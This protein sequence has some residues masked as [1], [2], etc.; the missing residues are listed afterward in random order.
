[1]NYAALALASFFTCACVNEE[2][3]DSQAG[4]SRP[5]SIQT[6]TPVGDPVAARV[7][8]EV[9]VE[10]DDQTADLF[11]E[12][13]EGASLPGIKGVKYERLFPDA[14]EWE[15]RHR[16][17]G[18]HKWFKVIYEES[19]NANTAVAVL[20]EVRGVVT[21]EAPMEKKLLGIPFNDPYAKTYQW[22]YFNDGTMYNGFVKGCDINV[23]PVWENYTAGDSHVIVSIV[24]QGIQINHPDLNGVVLAGGANGS[25]NFTTG[26]Y[27]ITAGEH[28]CHVA[29]IVGGINNNGKGICGVAGGSDGKGGVTM[30]SCQ[31]FGTRSGDS[32]A[33]IVWG[34]DHGAVISQNSWGYNYDYNNDG[35]L[36]GSEYTAAMNATISS[37]DKAA[38]DYFVK[39]A[40]CDSDGNQLPD[41]PMKG[42]IVIFAAG[43]DNVGNGA[44]AN[45]SKVMA[46]GA[47]GPDGKRASYSN[48]GDW[49]DICAPGGE[50]D[51][52]SSSNG[53]S[54]IL[55][56]VDGSDYG[57]MCGTSMACPMVSGVAALVVSYFGGQGFTNTELW[58]ML[59]DNENRT[60]IPSSDKIAGMVDAYAI[61]EAN[62]NRND[63]PVISTDYKGDFRV[64]V[65]ESLSVDY[66]LTDPEGE[67]CT[68]SISGDGSATLSKVSNGKYRLT[69][70]GIAKNIGT[71]KATLTAKD[72]RD[73]ETS[74]EVSYTI[75]QNYPP[76]IST[77]YTGNYK[78][79]VGEILSINY[80]ATDQDGDVCTFTFSGD[81]SATMTKTGNNSCRV[82][83]KTTAANV[84][85]H[86]ATLKAADGKG[87]EDSVEIEYVILA[88]NAPIIE[89]LS[90]FE[91]D[92]PVGSDVTL[93]YKVTDPDGDA[94]TVS[95]ES[96]GS[97]LLFNGS[98]NNFSV[99]IQTSQR[100]IGEHTSVI[101]ATDATGQKT[102]ETI[103][104]KIYQNY[105]PVISTT[106]TGDYTVL[107]GNSLSIDFS[108]TDAN[109]DEL[110]VT[111]E[112]D[113]SSN[114]VKTAPGAY[115]VVLDV[116]AA[117]AGVHNA[118]IKADDSKGG[119]TTY[120]ITYTIINNHTPKV[121]LVGTYENEVAVGQS[122]QA[123]VKV[124]DQD[125][126]QLNVTLEGDGSSTLEAL[127]GGQY[128]VKFKAE[129][130]YVG[131]HTVSVKA[132]DPYGASASQ[133]ITY[134]I[135]V[136]QAPVIKTSYTGPTVLKWYEKF[137]ASFSATDPEGK[138][139]LKFS[140]VSSNPISE[141]KINGTS[142]TVNIGDGSGKFHGECTITAT[143]EDVLGL[144]ASSTLTYTVLENR[145][146][147]L[148]RNLSDMVL[149]SSGER[150][151]LDLS[152]YWSEPDGE[153]MTI[154][155]VSDNQDV[156]SVSGSGTTYF[157]KA[158]KNGV[159]TITMTAKDGFGAVTTKE[160]KIGVYDD[161]VGPTLYPN[162]VKTNLYVRV[163]YEREVK[164]Q[165]YSEFGALVKTFNGNAS[166]FVPFEA[167][168]SSLA[169]GRYKVKVSYGDSSYEKN[170]VK[171]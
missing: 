22:Q 6:E 159:A 118:T 58:N 117:N 39:Y 86:K 100:F 164:L 93:L 73:A 44:P 111:Y 72:A 82:D 70:N 146:P 108:I 103:S 25:K 128:A 141:P 75:F 102:Q 34:A 50:H 78:A 23:V 10:L 28:G 113:G 84:G 26:N 139:P 171:L 142:A 20:G 121:T 137:S 168:M 125:G 89:A 97:A 3:V 123:V 167:D 163:G 127:S 42:G 92:I 1:M 30:M 145:A 140:V 77:T 59:I 71:H 152:Q 11:C 162:P 67:E 104:Y 52:F 149:S 122:L 133:S 68:M 53:K 155:C 27:T 14:G 81:G 76:V 57:F 62:V 161:S 36:T 165:V 147:E 115:R 32:Q 144:K 132:V 19:V 37:S 120:P 135:Y 2:L 48:F 47:T 88:I 157:F 151:T 107:V 106:Y 41:S 18:L 74:I 96:D 158:G 143:A 109:N 69:I 49:V 85:N 29:G 46:V 95:I 43:N 31:I 105:P 83:V 119:V 21:A 91:H 169:P 124:E 54:Y 61:F 112:N 148:V 170:I 66:T 131:N 12:N 13:I 126:D 45:Y 87:G 35:Q 51:R 56:C 38:V 8:K 90:T 101:T 15:P 98:D 24:D 40:G 9:I 110:K 33:A 114:L 80:T 129:Q 16:E 60:I 136:N 55:S 94:V 156:V 4:E 154:T 5:N 134:K 63:P 166:V 7:V 99:V 17:A 150:M 130:A 64:M 138:T 79:R 160:F 116:S 153:N 65:G